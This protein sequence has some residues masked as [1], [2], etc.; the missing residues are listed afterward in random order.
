VGGD[1]AACSIASIIGIDQLRDIAGAF[2]IVD[3][4]ERVGT[5][6]ATHLRSAT[7]LPSMG[8][9][10]PGRLDVWIANDGGQLLRY[11]FA[12]Q[13]LDTTLDVSGINDPATVLEP[14]ADVAASPQP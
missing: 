10:V 11:A 6:P 5:V 2:T 12:G 3:P 4:N 8:V 1:P 14:P 7:G 13:G 9:S